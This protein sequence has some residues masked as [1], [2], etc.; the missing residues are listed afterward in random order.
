MWLP[1]SC[2]RQKAAG[3]PQHAWCTTAAVLGKQVL[4][5]GFRHPFLSQ[6]FN[7]FMV[8]IWLLPGGPQHS[9]W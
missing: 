4:H 3:H 2:H 1:S 5:K 9:P 8:K 6:Q 7:G